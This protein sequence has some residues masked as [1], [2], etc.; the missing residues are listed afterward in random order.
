MPETLT[1]TDNR[2]GKTYELP[3]EH[4]T[5]KAIDL[6]KI[7]TD[8][9][10]VRPDGIRSWLHEHRGLQE[11]H[12][13]HRR[14]ARHSALSGLS[15]RA[16]GRA[17]ELPRGGLPALLR[18]AAHARPAR[19][20]RGHRAQPHHHPRADQEVHRR[21]SPRFA[22]DG[23]VPLHRRRA[24]P[25]STKRART[26]FDAQNRIVQFERMVAKMPTIAAFCYRPT[27]SACRLPIP[28]TTSAMPATS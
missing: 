9:R 10:R 13:L 14:R 3:I 4:G 15:H 17:L 5:I 23:R 6:R 24:C 11:P 20:F 2:T 28:T 12:H 27:R 19:R 16:T 26:S 21:L 7:K 25:P 8:P 1:I 18:R 22:P